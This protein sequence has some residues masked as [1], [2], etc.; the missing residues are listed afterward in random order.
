MS[1]HYRMVLQPDGDDWIVV[2]A[3]ADGTV[4]RKLSEYAGESHSFWWI[5]GAT[6][7]QGAEAAHVADTMLGRPYDYGFYFH[8]AL[9]VLWH[10]LC[11]GFRPHSVDAS[12]ICDDKNRL[13]VCTEVIDS[14]D[15]V[16]GMPDWDRGVAPTPMAFQK[17]IGQGWVTSLSASTV[18]GRKDGD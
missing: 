16:P 6:D 3:L 7:D 9:Q 11:H 2:E 13:E 1:R 15:F 12:E 18:L 5:T 17:A 10:W 4:R 8:C 14:C